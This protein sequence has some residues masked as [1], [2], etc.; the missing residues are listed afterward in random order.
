MSDI[1]GAPPPPDPGPYGGPWAEQGVLAALLWDPE[2]AGAIGDLPPEAFADPAHRAVYTAM[3]TLLAASQ[4]LEVVSLA[5][6]LRS[7]GT[8]DRV[9]GMPAL[10]DLAETPASPASAAYYADQVRAAALRRRVADTLRVLLTAAADPLRDAA[11]TATDGAAQ[12]TAVA[13]GDARHPAVTPAV[14]AVEE[15]LRYLERRWDGSDAP[16]P[17]PWPSLDTVGGGLARGEVVVVAA[18]PSVGKTTFAVQVAT[19]TARLGHRVLYV[20]YE[21]SPARLVLQVAA[22]TYG[23]DRYGWLSGLDDAGQDGVARTLMQEIP[24]WPLDWWRAG[25]RPAWDAIR[26]EM[27]RLG[28][29]DPALGLVVVDHL[30]WV[31]LP[32]QRSRPEELEAL[33]ADIKTTAERYQVPILVC[34][35]L[36]R[37][38]DQQTEPQL[39]DLGWS[40]GIEQAADKVW[41]LDR[42]DRANPASDRVVYVRK[43]R[44]GPTG[45]VLLLWDPRPARLLDP[46]APTEGGR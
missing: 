36:R 17:T 2:T 23:L 5:D 8:L 11:D 26:R 29:Q 21:M 32:G 46:T 25:D 28:R 38:V 7:A 6:A 35:Q 1:A 45:H 10:M 34:Q 19:Q 30:Q 42:V 27:A 20:S 33:C 14:V 40:A 43:H 24:A 44:D 9:G 22:Q 3:R 13:A 39:G 41:M 31:P 4:P 18:R 15:A 37:Q 12:L 16:L